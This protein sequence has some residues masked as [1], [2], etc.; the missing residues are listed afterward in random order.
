MWGFGKSKVKYDRQILVWPKKF[1]VETTE[2][3]P[4][5]QDLILVVP[6]VKVDE[7][8]GKF[9]ILDAHL[10]LNAR[11][12][13]FVKVDAGAEVPIG[14]VEIEIEGVRAEAYLKAHLESVKTIFNKT[15]ESLDRNPEIPASLL[16]PVAEGEYVNPGHNIRQ[17][18]SIRT[19]PSKVNT[20]LGLAGHNLAHAIY[21]RNV[22][23]G[24]HAISQGAYVRSHSVSETTE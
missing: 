24:F 18:I 23:S 15:V 13:D 22:L 1:V 19:K 16:I 17:S 12:G 9:K 14:K 7:I 3:K 5:E 21:R 20:N 8:I 10:A 11:K 2:N 4:A 6:D